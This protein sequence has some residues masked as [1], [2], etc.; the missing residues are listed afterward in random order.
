[1]SLIVLY[2]LH[3]TSVLSFYIDVV[4]TLSIRV[5]FTLTFDL[6]FS[7]STCISGIGDPDVME[8]QVRGIFDLE[9]WHWICKANLYLGNGRPDCHGS[10]GWSRYYALMDAALTGVPLTLNF[11]GQIVSRNG[12]PD[13]HETKGM[14]VDRVPWRETQSLSD[15]E[16]ED[17]ARDRVDLRCRR[18]RRLA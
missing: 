15:L 9:L 4:L 7:R 11:Q 10:K 16:A 3:S 1:M 18:F 6:E 13:C 8:R 12:S 17:A 2:F 5:P 14:G